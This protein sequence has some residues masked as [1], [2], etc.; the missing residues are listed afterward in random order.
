MSWCIPCIVGSTDI[1]KFKQL[2]RR[3]DQHQTEHVQR[4]WA[5]HWTLLLGWWGCVVFQQDGP[6]SNHKIILCIILLFYINLI[7]NIYE[8]GLHINCICCHKFWNKIIHLINQHN[9][10]IL[11]TVKVHLQGGH[12][13][14]WRGSFFTHS[15]LWMCQL[16]CMRMV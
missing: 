12:A 5:Q 11:G 7:F 1:F 13:G 6:C 2:R 14:Q 10:G 9:L 3:G 15:W 16:P 8:L 4:N